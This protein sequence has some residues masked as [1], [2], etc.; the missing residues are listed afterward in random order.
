ME[1]FVASLGVFSSFLASSL[2]SVAHGGSLANSPQARANMDMW[3]L[4]REE[5]FGGHL[6][7]RGDF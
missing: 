7:T 4:P 2:A 1:T 3:V 6:P 5:A